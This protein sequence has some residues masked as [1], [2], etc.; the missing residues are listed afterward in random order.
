MFELQTIQMSHGALTPQK[1]CAVQTRSQAKSQD[2]KPF[3]S[4]NVP[5]PMDDIVTA[6]GLKK[7]QLEDPTLR[8]SRE[9]AETQS[10][11]V[12]RSQATSRF[13]Y[14]NGILY[15]QFHAPNVEFGNILSRLWFL[16]YIAHM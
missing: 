1:A 15:R 14:R 11:K 10:E 3:H 9:L 8:R 2:T 5:K 6:E 16:E 13:L 4:L 7:A 12:S